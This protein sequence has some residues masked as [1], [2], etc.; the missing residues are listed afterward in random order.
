[1]RTLSARNPS[2]WTGVT[3]N[4][5]YLLDGAV[6]TLIDAGVGHPEH[7]AEIERTLEG[8]SLA[9]VLVTHGHPD[10]ASGIPALV[11]RWPGLRLRQLGP[12]STSAAALVD[13]EEL[14]AG[15]T[16]LRTVAT[17]GHA[18]DHCCF[19]DEASRD[20]YCGDLIRAGGT[21]AI[22]A[23]A[24]GDMA[25][26]LRSLR[27]VR[28]LDPN[29]LFPGHGAVIEEPAAA[30]DQYLRHRAERESQVLQA[31]AAGESTPAGIAA[32]I[33]GGLTSSLQAA[34]VD[35]VLAHLVKLEGEGRVLKTAQG[36]GMTDHRGSGSQVRDPGSGI[37]DPDP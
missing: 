5:T 33:Y 16:T 10:H 21:I 19:A 7:V 14:R 34:A 22:A 31:L 32:R 30:I 25:A 4:N 1:M 23:S 28:A 26:Y 15:N 8:R 17:P 37:R 9:Q 11:A 18:P 13:G 6:P 24:G 36:W 2:G 27:L 12:A 3:G 29:R 20:V 35:T